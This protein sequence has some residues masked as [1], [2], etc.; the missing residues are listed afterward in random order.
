MGA[1]DPIR[2]RTKENEATIKHRQSSGNTLA[3]LLLCQAQSAIV[4]IRARAARGSPPRPSVMPRR[5]A[6][7]GP[8]I[9][10]VAAI[11]SQAGHRHMSAPSQPPQAFTR[12]ALYAHH[13]WSAAVQGR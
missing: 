2:H 4:P 9:Q 1:V 12:T 7:R 3:K 6:C 11:V 10:Q 5:R 8:H 13:I